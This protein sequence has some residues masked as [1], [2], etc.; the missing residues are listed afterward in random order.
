MPS[1]KQMVAGADQAGI[2]QHRID[3]P[4]LAGLD[5]FREQPA[6]KIE[7]RGDKEF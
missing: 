1:E 5:A 7:Q 4:E 6:M 2:E 3:D